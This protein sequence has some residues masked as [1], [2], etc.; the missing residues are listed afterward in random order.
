MGAW[1][2]EIFNNEMV[3][4]VYVR[5]VPLLYTTIAGVAA[6]K[7]VVVAGNTE[8][9]I[10]YHTIVPVEGVVKIVVELTFPDAPKTDILQTQG[11]FAA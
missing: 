9:F 2:T 8:I 6:A 10:S 4:I 3:V 5:C 1:I 11:W 7:A